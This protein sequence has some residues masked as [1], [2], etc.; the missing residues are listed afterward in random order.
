MRC[1][2]R[3]CRDE[4]ELVTDRLGRVKAICRGCERR[5]RGVCALCPRRVEGTVGKAKYC[6]EHKVLTHRRDHHA[7]KQR[8][9]ERAVES[10]KVRRRLNPHRAMT[11]QEAGRRGGL[12]GG[13]ARSASLT[14]ARRTEIAQLAARA[15]W[16]MVRNAVESVSC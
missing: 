10:A 15:R 8:Y 2:F 5:R 11:P 13:P 9:Y 4:L 16:G 6:R 1:E 7:W 14:A 12:K 3:I